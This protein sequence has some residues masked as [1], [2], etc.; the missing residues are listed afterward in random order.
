MIMDTI[1]PKA[2]FL[3]QKKHC[4]LQ[5]N[6]SAL[7]NDLVRTTVWK[8]PDF[9]VVSPRKQCKLE[10]L[11]KGLDWWFSLT[12]FKVEIPWNGLDKCRRGFYDLFSDHGPA[13]S[14]QMSPLKISPQPVHHFENPLPLIL[15]WST[16]IYEF[17]ETQHL[18]FSDWLCFEKALY[19][20]RSFV[21][22]MQGGWKRGQCI[23]I[24]LSYLI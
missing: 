6:W 11:G 8:F 10:L 15:S 1:K 3:C 18:T 5:I 20:K 13:S 24:I 23:R 19:V 7:L 22:V 17:L 14:Q 21:K 2:S 9:K 12:F 16:L 4:L